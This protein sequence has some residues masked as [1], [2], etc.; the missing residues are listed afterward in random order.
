MVYVLSP[1]QVVLARNTRCAVIIL[2]NVSLIAVYAAICATRQVKDDL[3]SQKPAGLHT[4]IFFLTRKNDLQKKREI[5]FDTAQTSRSVSHVRREQGRGRRKE[6]P[7]LR[8]SSQETASTVAA[9]NAQAIS[10]QRSFSA[11]SASTSVST[12]RLLAKPR[13]G[14]VQAPGVYLTV[15]RLNEGSLRSTHILFADATNPQRRH[16]EHC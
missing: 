9:F 2:Q 6:C 7:C 3:C 15:Y 5:K 8:V 14:H 13:T 16:A 10:S 1:A 12:L 4:N 11:A